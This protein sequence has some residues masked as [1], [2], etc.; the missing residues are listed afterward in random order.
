[1]FTPPKSSPRSTETVLCVPTPLELERLRRVAPAVLEEG[2][3]RTVA[4][5]GF[6]PVAAAARG[7]QLMA[8]HPGAP[9][10]LVGIAGRYEGGPAPGEAA[11]FGRV[12][13]DGVGADEGPAHLLPGD[14]GLPQWH[15]DA[16]AS[17][18][19]QTLA[20][21][22]PEGAPTLLTVCAASGDPAAAALRT[23]R[24][25]AAAED[26]EGFGL[27]FAG[28]LAGSSV[29]IVRGISNEA[30]D[31]D[32]ARWRIDDALAAAAALAAELTS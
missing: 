25:G 1:M 28:H 13:L 6:G 17:R 11:R 15:G 19:E 31:R 12:A 22:G 3:W 21:G 7:A 24:H 27:A 5:L 20:L 29:E 10:L 26:M 30:G 2:R 23:A 18:V 8:T 4:V 16:S 9:F 14:M 32:V